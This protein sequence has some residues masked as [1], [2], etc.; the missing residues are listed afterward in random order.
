MGKVIESK[1]LNEFVQN[2]TV[3]HVPDHKPGNSKEAAPLDV[4]PAAPVVETTDKKPEEVDK[5]LEKAIETEEAVPTLSEDS[6]KYVNK[7]HRLRKEAQEE[8]E[9]SESLA[10]EQFNRAVLAEERAKAL[11]AE[12]SKVKAP[13]ET[14]KVEPLKFP[15]ATE[16]VKDGV[17]NQD[18]YQKA[19]SAYNKEETKRIIDE[20]RLSREQAQLAK[21]LGESADQARK[22]HAD[23][24]DVMKA[25]NGTPADMVP[26]FVLTYINE[27]D[28][29]GEISY[30]LLKNPEESQRIAR[31]SPI[32]GIA[33]LGKLEAKLVAPE[34]DKATQSAQAQPAERPG[35]PPP[36][37]PLSTSGS[38]S[39]NTDPAKMS[40]AELRAYER[41][42]RRKK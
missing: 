21:K 6:R 30:Y 3:T 5:T 29:A 41:E 14:P 22:A 36:I 40:F 32:R 23:F 2:G 7:Q 1:G 17:F 42:K 34:A 28:I 20:E 37:T 31:L 33:E 26:Q 38:G 39:T 35:A 12:L 25:A 13:V 8:A 18:D 24:D 10:R 15:L 11:E 16:F 19:V 4:K 27:S 9:L